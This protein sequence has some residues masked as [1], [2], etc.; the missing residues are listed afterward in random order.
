MSR[1][2]LTVG[3]MQKYSAT[4]AALPD[5]RIFGRV[6]GH[7]R[8]RSDCR[9]GIAGSESSSAAIRP[10]WATK[11]ERHLYAAVV[12]ILLSSS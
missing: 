6:A 8:G 1:S 4:P 5:S 2:Q 3:P 11:R 7:E 10:A 9:F 12:C